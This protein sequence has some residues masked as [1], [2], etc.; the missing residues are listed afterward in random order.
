MS[1][2]IPQYYAAET[3]VHSDIRNPMSAEVIN[4]MGSH[5]AVAQLSD[6]EV[7]YEIAGPEGGEFVMMVHGLAGHYHIWD[8]NFGAFVAA[9]FRVL[10]MDLYGRGL[11]KRIQEPHTSDLYVRQLSELLSHLKIE[12]QINLMGLSM[13][14]AVISHFTKAFPDRVKRMVYVDPYGISTPNDPIALLMRPRVI[15]EGIIYLFGHQFIR[16]AAMNGMKERRKARKFSKWFAAP[17]KVEGSKRALLA[18]LRHFML[19]DHASV[20]KE[21]EQMNIPKML[22]W[23]RHDRVLKPEYGE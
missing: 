1:A 6:G 5:G 15:G 21:V 13:G 12:A 18:C 7:R 8:K 4:Q 2:D 19:E 14:G 22:V 11:S 10:R 23:G 3:N 9:G 16:L 17:M 20:M